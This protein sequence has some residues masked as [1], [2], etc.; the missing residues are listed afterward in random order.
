MSSRFDSPCRVNEFSHNTPK[1]TQY[2]LARWN[3]I[4]KR[5]PPTTKVPDCS[6]ITPEKFGAA[7]SWGRGAK[8]SCRHYYRKIEGRKVAC[9]NNSGNLRRPCKNSGAF[10]AL[11]EYDANAALAQLER[12]VNKEERRR[13]I[14]QQQDSEMRDAI[15]RRENK[16]RQQRLDRKKQDKNP[17]QDA[18]DERQALWE[19][20]V[21]ESA[22]VMGTNP[23][24]DTSYRD[25]RYGIG[26][27][28]ASRRRR[29][30]RRRARTRNQRKSRHR[31]RRRGGGGT[32]RARRARK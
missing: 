8:N 4:T 5:K 29:S 20:G 3:D 22:V 1:C 26:G 28:R 25:D 23:L 9:R 21:R 12:L 10:G 17:E 31:R 7:A 11:K 24:P 30:R 6:H 32:R 16:R 13:A 15:I 27:G 19:R 14:L 18:A 2:L